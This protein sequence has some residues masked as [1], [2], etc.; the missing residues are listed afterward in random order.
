M[1]GTSGRITM[2]WDDPRPS[3]PR[4]VYIHVP[5][6]R[7]KCSYCDFYSRSDVGS[8]EHPRLVRHTLALLRGWIIPDVRRA[9]LHTLYVGGGT[10]TV[11]GQ[12]LVTLIKGVAAILPF[13][14]DAEVTVEANPESLTP[15]LVEAL[16]D[17]GVTR[18]SVGVQSLDDGALERLDRRHD[19]AAAMAALRSVA[20][21]GLEPAADLICGIPG[22]SAAAWERSLEGVVEA[23]AV[24]VSVYPL[25]VEEGTPLAERIAAGTAEAPD[26]DAVVDGMDAAARTLEALGLERYEVANYAMPGHRSRHNTAY[27]TGRPYIGVGGG[28]HGMLDAAH[29]RACMLAPDDGRDVGRVR[30]SYVADPFPGDQPSPLASLELLTTLEAAREDAMLG[31]RMTD[32][33]DESVAERAGVVGVMESLVDDGLVEHDNGRW[34]PT[35]RGWLLGNEV[36]GRIWNAER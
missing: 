14:S 23:G 5:V 35:T 29:A 11:L 8:T 22:M 33:I 17:A 30:Y 3:L 1:S 4:H 12:E 9:P 36:F 25:T 7:S 31:M 24:H 19:S 6:C 34:R 28:A 18:V 20:E 16:A 2:P 13:T 21:A 32:G 10:P 27:W 15:A 26:E